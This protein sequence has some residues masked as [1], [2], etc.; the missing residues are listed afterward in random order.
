MCGTHA[1]A[2][3]ALTR[4]YQVTVIQDAVCGVDIADCA[5]MRDHIELRGGLYQTSDMV[6]QSLGMHSG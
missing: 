6:L 5:G 4:G 2:L 3:D 1:T